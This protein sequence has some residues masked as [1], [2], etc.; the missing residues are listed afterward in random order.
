MLN[1]KERKQPHEKFTLKDNG[2]SSMQEV[3]YP[4]EFN[5]ADKESFKKNPIKK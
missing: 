2:L 3:I 1:M 5:R 4:K